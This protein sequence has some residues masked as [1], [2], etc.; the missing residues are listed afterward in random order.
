MPKHRGLPL[1]LFIIPLLGLTTFLTSESL[2]AIFLKPIFHTLPLAM[3]ASHISTNL[4]H[5]GPKP[6]MKIDLKA[7]KGRKDNTNESL[8]QFYLFLGEHLIN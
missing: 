5:V 4:K 2:G 8:A 6:K 7:E 1:S 3:L